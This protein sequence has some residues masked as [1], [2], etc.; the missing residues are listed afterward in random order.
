MN[1]SYY[2]E[3]SKT[4]FINEIV[5]VYAKK[6][7]LGDAFVLASKESNVVGRYI[8]IR[9]LAEQK[10]TYKKELL[11]CTADSSKMIKEMLEAVLV[12]CPEWEEDIKTLLSSKKSQEREIAILVLKK[13]GASKYQEEFAKALEK[14][15][16]KKVKELLS[17]CL[18]VTMETEEAELKNDLDGIVKEMH[19]GGKMRKIQ[20][21]YETPFVSVHKKGGEETSEEYLQALVL[22]YADMSIPGVNK[23]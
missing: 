3:Q 17:D 21:A 15:K 19:K 22:C 10:E 9:F 14:E 20:W 4:F 2:S 18:G 23:Q 12:D 5:K 16:S 7:D 8:S 13:W 1:N 6:K 11:T